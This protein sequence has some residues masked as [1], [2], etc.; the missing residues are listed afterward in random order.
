MFAMVVIISLFL[1]DPGQ[2]STGTV[3]L[4]GIKCPV[5]G[6]SAVKECS[7]DYQGAKLYF[8][9]NA[10]KNRFVADRKQYETKANHQLVVTGQYVQAQC[11]IRFVPI[12]A[13]TQPKKQIA[14]VTIR[15][16]CQNCLNRLESSRKPMEQF[17]TVYGSSNFN[18]VFVPAKTVVVAKRN[19]SLDR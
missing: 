1:G 19:S 17:Q 4:K 13:Q 11:P 8:D 9:S 5:S 6:K 7:C 10:S 14:G 3:D 12:T 2:D 18:R 16:C 15:F